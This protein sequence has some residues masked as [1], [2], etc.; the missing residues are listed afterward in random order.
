MTRIVQLV[1]KPQRRGGEAFVLQ[2]SQELRRRG[3][4]VMIVYLYDHDGS[5][6]LP[7]GPNDHVLGGDEWHPIETALGIHPRLF[8][9]LD[10]LVEQFDPEII[11]VNGGRTVKYG[12]LL[13]RL[14]PRARWSLVYRNIGN[15]S[16]WILGTRRVLLYRW[17]MRQVDGLAA[18][19]SGALSSLQ[20]MSPKNLQ[21]TIIPTGVDPQVLVPRRT[22]EELRVLACT[23]MDAPVLLFV[24]SLSPE[25]RPER[26]LEILH[27]VRPTFPSTRLWIVGDGPLRPA[28]ESRARAIGVDDA[29]CFFG[30]QDDVGSFFSTADLLLLTSD[31]EGVPAVVLE[32]GY[33]GIPVVA[34]AVGGVPECVANQE[35]GLLV[36]PGDIVAASE[37][38]S[39]LL[40]N[41]TF[42]EHLGRTA[43]QVVR[44]RFTIS[45][46]A[47]Q[48]KAFG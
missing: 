3:N 35:T 32:A 26:V 42:R 9:R 8:R 27:H 30:V 37:A 6:P 34:T 16:D 12:A 43:R 21:C 29:T 1:H 25:K 24:G 47:E 46:V 23:P 33:C 44:E 17:I 14:R 7:V 15:P 5:E 13:R 18:I 39:L 2:L 10:R 36:A 31:T 28:L 4:A 19:S 20:G 41:H 45:A 38:C 40:A 48:F 22:A 11:Q